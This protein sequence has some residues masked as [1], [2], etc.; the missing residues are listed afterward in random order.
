MNDIVYFVKDEALNEELKYSLRTLSNFPHRKVFIYGGCPLGIIPDEYIFVE[1]DQENKWQNVHKMLIMACENKNISKSFWLFND[2]FFVMEKVEKPLN[3]YNGDLYKRIVEIENVFG[4]RTSY[5]QLLRDTCKELESMGSSTLNYTLH[6]PML[7]NR[8]KM[9]ELNAITDFPG[10][11]SLYANYFKIG[12]KEMKDV[13]IVSPTREYKGGVY[14]S[15]DE[16]SF[17]GVCGQQI[18]DKFPDKCKY[19]L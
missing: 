17:N 2:D 10:F 8:K 16:K 1:Q 18:R 13:K 4:N 11:R 5:S 19:E 9:L 7:I 15:T 3:Y 12:G 14:L 6:I